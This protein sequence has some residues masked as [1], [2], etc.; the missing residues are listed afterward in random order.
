MSGKSNEMKHRIQRLAVVTLLILM[1]W[2]A[3][4]QDAETTGPP[5]PLPPLRPLDTTILETAQGPVYIEAI[6]NILPF[7][8]MGSLPK[9]LP[10]DAIRRLSADKLIEGAEWI[11]IRKAAWAA[12]H[13]NEEERFNSVIANASGYLNDMNEKID[14]ATHFLYMQEEVSR[15]L[16]TITEEEIAK[17]YE[18]NKEHFWHPNQFYMRHAILLTYVPYVVKDGD[19]LE[20]IAQLN[21]EGEDWIANI[22]ADLPG[23]PVRRDPEGIEKPLI[24]GE[25]LLLPMTDEKALERREELE[26][27]V[28]RVKAGEM[29]FADL[30]ENYSESELKSEELGPLPSGTR[31]MLQAILDQA[32]VLAP[33]EISDIFRTKHGWQVIE[34]TRKTQEGYTPIEEV[35]DQL[36]NSINT[37]ARRKQVRK[38]VDKLFANPALVVHY[39]LIS[40]GDSIEDDAVV[41]EFKDLKLTWAGNQF[42]E[43]WNYFNKPTD[44]KGIDNLI[45]NHR[46]IQLILLG[47]WRDS[48]MEEDPNGE[49][50]R[51]INDITA[52]FEGTA[53]LSFKATLL[54]K[55]RIT[56]SDKQDY[57][58]R[59]KDTKFTVPAQY[60]IETYEIHLTREQLQELPEKHGIMLQKARATL[61][62]ALGSI[63][64]SEAFVSEAELARLEWSSYHAPD[65]FL[66]KPLP[67]S[68]FPEEYQELIGTLQVGQWTEPIVD[69]EGKRAVS[70]LLKEM[71][72]AQTLPFD[73]KL[74][75]AVIDGLL[76]EMTDE[77]V[78]DLEKEYLERAQVKVV[79]QD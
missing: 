60:T 67:L 68:A 62:S 61:F 75:N 54:G 76:E 13:A 26:A 63:A 42:G 16:P 5:R 73:E 58:E 49:V 23:R 18:E 25:T 2:P 43:Y 64:D 12:Y 77:L 78:A 31:P 50:A 30:A 46:D 37:E 28:A 27:L 57:Y 56:E 66:G 45:M 38:A 22:R 71:T 34:L 52:T 79:L 19:T 59:N 40:Q 55:E 24:E 20:S 11:A 39:D 48:Q 29:S 1:A 69:Q 51:M 21:G 6:A 9:G 3:M 36:V 47:D 74:E 65:Q 17:A 14:Q 32:D 70:I 33:G 41:V 4:A 72:P 8:D 44:K 15:K 7:F 53:F 10:L 35:R